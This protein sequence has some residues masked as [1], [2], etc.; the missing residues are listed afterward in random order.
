VVVVVVVLVVHRLLPLLPSV[1]STTIDPVVVVNMSIEWI[2][3]IR[4]QNDDASLLASD[5]AGETYW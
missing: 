3:P 5:A 1:D 2:V 4:R